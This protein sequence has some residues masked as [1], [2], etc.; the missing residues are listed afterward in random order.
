MAPWGEWCEHVQLPAQLGVQSPASDNMSALGSSML[1]C[2]F[3]V[4][5]NLGWLYMI[6]WLQ[7]AKGVV[8]RAAACLLVRLGQ[9]TKHI[10][11]H[12]SASAAHCRLANRPLN[13]RCRGASWPELQPACWLACASPTCHKPLALVS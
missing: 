8:A 9:S 2:K 4:C 3:P 13:C 6:W 7:V 5:G 10:C 12:L 1:P 11:A